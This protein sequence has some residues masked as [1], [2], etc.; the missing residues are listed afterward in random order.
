MYAS[1]NRY[2]V[3]ATPIGDPAEV[4][5]RLGAILARSP[6]FVAAVVVED[7]MGA[8]FTIKLFDDQASLNAATPLAERWVAEHRGMLAPGATEVATGEVVAQKGL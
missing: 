3:N 8:L 2:H 6:G 4:G 7:G 5:W 1:I